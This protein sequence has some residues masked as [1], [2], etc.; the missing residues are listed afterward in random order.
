MRRETASSTC[1]LSHHT[2]CCMGHGLVLLA[3]LISSTAHLTP[4]S[5]ALSRSRSPNTAP[6]LPSPLS[7]WFQLADI[8]TD[9]IDESEYASFVHVMPLSPYH[10]LASPARLAGTQHGSTP[11]SI[12]SRPVRT[13]L[14]MAAASSTLL[15]S[16]PHSSSFLHAPSPPPPQSQR[17]RGGASPGLQ[18]R[19]CFTACARHRALAPRLFDQF[20][21]LGAQ[22][23]SKALSRPPS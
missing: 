22:R 13:P 1:G 14:L 23:S 16:P 4:R 9:N 3:L 8:N 5:H 2:P 18:T 12:T 19:L 11:R 15:N 10:L 21:R 7:G 17:A 20:A 6:L